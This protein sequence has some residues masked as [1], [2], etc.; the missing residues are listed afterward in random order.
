MMKKDIEKL[1][2][3]LVS[4]IKE[5]ATDLAKSSSYIGLLSN[6]IKFRAL[7]E[8]FINL[9]FLERKHIGTDIFSD[10]IP[11]VENKI[12]STE[13][14]VQESKIL[15]S[16][17]PEEDVGIQEILEK[18]DDLNDYSDLLPSKNA[19]KIQID[20]NDRIAFL[21]QL[22]NGNEKSMD[23]IINTL[24]QMNSVNESRQYILDLKNQMNWTDKDEY[25]DRLETLIAKRFD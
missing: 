14:N 7:H 16:E 22:F 13:T 10:P 25:I 18:K 15:E 1:K 23:T 4:E 9:K 19:K 6:E 11:V 21:N 17:I 24:N 20:F 5:L 12:E 2:E 8:K 3:E